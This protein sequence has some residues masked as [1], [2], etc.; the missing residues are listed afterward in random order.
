MDK[1][2]TT[3]GRRFYKNYLEHAKKHYSCYLRDDI[4][5]GK[6]DEN[7]MRDVFENYYVQVLKDFIRIR[8]TYIYG[9]ETEGTHQVFQDR[10]MY[11]DIL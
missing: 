3:C 7:K 10:K 6:I 5:V 9:R 1:L 4:W 8:P 11:D 2:D